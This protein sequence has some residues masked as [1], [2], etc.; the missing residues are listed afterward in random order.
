MSIWVEPRLI[1]YRSISGAGKRVLET[2]GPP[3][4]SRHSG[5]SLLHPVSVTASFPCSR[6]QGH[7]S[8]LLLW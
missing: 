5:L 1:S 3:W 8:R 2:E 6:D 7:F 4:V